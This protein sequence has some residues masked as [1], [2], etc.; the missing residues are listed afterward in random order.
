M[1]RQIR[2]KFSYKGVFAQARRNPF[3]SSNYNDQYANS[4][5]PNAAYP[6]NAANPYNAN[7]IPNQNPYNN[8]YGQNPVIAHQT[9]VLNQAY[10]WM[11]GGLCLTAIIALAVS[12]SLSLELLIYSNPIVLIG[13]IIAELA[14]VFIISIRINKLSPAMATTLFLVY[15]A[16]NGITLSFVFLVYTEA[17]I[18]AAFFVT[19]GMFG[20]LSLYGY[21]TKRDLSM[22][23]R[24]AF[25]ALVGLILA[26]IVNIFFVSPGLSWALTYLG[27]VIFAA[28]TAYDTQKIKRWSLSV[29]PN[30]TTTIHRLGILGAL[31]LY[32][33]FINLFL[34][35]LRIMGGRR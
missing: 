16:L 1:L 20:A 24:I 28:L 17:S 14:M 6:N 34:R 3:V 18:T 23:G 2:Q 15:S 26:S 4:A 33:D 25:M 22:I 13:L 32:L 35:I 9:S 12:N 11:T 7:P 21:T 10:L 5:Y 19:A 31:T 8:A 30:D 29:N 27:V